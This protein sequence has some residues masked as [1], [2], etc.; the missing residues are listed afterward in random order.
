MS[1]FRIYLWLLVAIG[2]ISTILLAQGTVETHQTVEHT[3]Y[4]VEWPMGPAPSSA[5]PWARNGQIRFSRWDGGRIETAKGMLSGWPGLWPPE[6]EIINAMTNWYDPATI[7]FLKDAGINMVWVTFSNG[8]SNQTEKPH[9]EQVARYITECHKQGIHVM[10]YESIA[11]MFWQDM[12]KTVPESRNWPAIGKD[13]K[14]VPYGAASYKKI[15]YISRYMADPGNPQWLAY[16]RKR[17]DLAIDAGADGVMYDNNF[18]SDLGKLADVYRMIYEYGSSRKHDF[19]LMGNF[20]QKTYVINRL[21][22]AMTTEDGWEPGIYASDSPPIPD[23]QNALKVGPGLMVDNVG[24]FRVLDALTEGWKL[25]LVEDGRR[26]G[27]VREIAPM[28][29]D[30]WQLALAEAQSLGVSEELF[31]DDGFATGMW[32]GNPKA[33]EVIHAI[34]KY[35]RFFADHEEYYVGAKSAAPIAVVVDDASDG[36]PLLNALA[37]RNVLFEVIYARDLSASKLIHYSTVA[38]LTAHTVSDKGITVLESYVSGGGK[39]LAAGDSAT[40]DLD[41]K[42]RTRPSFF[43]QKT[44][45]GECL[46]L[47]RVPSA[48]ELAR[49]LKDDE[50]AREPTLDAPP[51]VIYNVTEQ[52]GGKHLIV[53]LLNYTLTPAENIRLRL[54]GEYQ[55]ATVLSPEATNAYPLAIKRSNGVSEVIVPT[56]RIYSLVVLKR[57]N[58]Q[59]TDKKLEGDQ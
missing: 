2:L 8:F 7:R 55:S 19:L 44:G 58:N 29:P 10:A 1:Y 17:I 28:Q 47:D 57:S 43:G 6:P 54:H 48:D 46:Y 27:E 42:T 53:H 51:G 52:A 14:P 45:K 34:G 9:Q 24:L 5:P 26:E 11:N 31:V 15:G 35:N 4:P 18:A 39:L 41:G 22:N 36:V 50:S 13:G 56:V 32:D 25:N 37:A 49:M 38:L 40:H 21:T 12:F 23:K 30:R 33:L 59:P 16:L 3:S 20:H